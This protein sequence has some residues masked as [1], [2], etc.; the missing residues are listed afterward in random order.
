MVVVEIL[1][2]FSSVLVFLRIF[3]IFAYTVAG[4]INFERAT[5]GEGLRSG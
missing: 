1:F 5:E 3:F 4:L 2:S